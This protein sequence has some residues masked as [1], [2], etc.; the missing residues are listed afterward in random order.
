MSRIIFRFSISLGFYGVLFGLVFGNSQALLA[1]ESL[2]IRVHDRTKSNIYHAFT[3]SHAFY[4]SFQGEPSLRVRLQW[5][6]AL[7][8]PAV[9]DADTIRDVQF[10]Q[11]LLLCEQGEFVGSL[12]TDVSNSKTD[13]FVDV[14]FG[15]VTS[16]NWVLGFTYRYKQYEPQRVLFSEVEVMQE[17]KH[18]EN[19]RLLPFL[20]PLA[21]SNSSSALDASADFKGDKVARLREIHHEELESLRRKHEA[22]QVQ[23]LQR[24][25]KYQTELSASQQENAS[26]QEDMALAL[27]TLEES[28]QKQRFIFQGAVVLLLGGA[29]FGGFQFRKN[30]SQVLLL[31]K[32]V[33]SS[34]K[35]HEE[36]EAR[37]LSRIR[38]LESGEYFQQALE[39][40]DELENS[41]GMVKSLSRELEI[42]AKQS[43]ERIVS[44]ELEIRD[45]QSL[46][47]DTRKKGFEVEEEKERVRQKQLEVEAKRL[48]NERL[49][50]QD[51]E[52]RERLKLS[53][54]HALC[55]KEKEIELQKAEAEKA[56]F[57]RLTKI[58]KLPL[59]HFLRFMRHK[60]QVVESAEFQ[61]E[62]HS[63]LV[64]LFIS[65]KKSFL[66]NKLIE[67]DRLEQILPDVLRINQIETIIDLYGEKIHTV[68]QNAALD[69][70]ERQ[71]KIDYWI[72]LRDRDIQELEGSS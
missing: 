56:F 20:N 3:I 8:S 40:K 27:T 51:E 28:Q 5:Q 35:D 32:G 46:Q 13:F 62:N 49:L 7:T 54:D 11:V 15:R 71:M 47:A 52:E 22:T 17:L 1:Q 34:E 58:S 41:K 33:A 29:V 14:R 6:E 57:L 36:E 44:L 60:L 64:Q 23:V 10:L 19:H 2:G 61:G 66:R 43:R 30:R 25:Q 39:L 67:P 68:K 18:I 55:M 4:E 21:A 63:E 53:H 65:L 31:E 72:R 50:A 42:Q 38:Q 26:L 69:E 16:L 9:D 45:L 24:I 48:E 12:S 59:Q 70:E 37:L